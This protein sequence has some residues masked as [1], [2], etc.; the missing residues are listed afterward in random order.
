MDE[1]A[2]KTRLR[3]LLETPGYRPA[4]LQEIAVKLQIPAKGRQ[5]L[6]VLVHRLQQAGEVAVSENGRLLSARKAGEQKA[7]ILSVGVRGGQALLL[8]PAQDPGPFFVPKED[9]NGAM[10]TDIVS[11]RL[12]KQRGRPPQ[13]VVMSVSERGFQEFLGTFH[14]VGKNGYVLP[15]SKYRE[16]IRVD[17]RGTRLLRENDMVLAKM[18]QYPHKGQEAVAEV[19]SAYGPSDSARACCNAILDR[20]HIR[21]AFPEEVIAQAKALPKAVDA[22][23]RLDLRALP[24]FTIDGAES[25]DLDDAVSVQE[26]E[27]GVR[28]GVHIADVSHYVTPGS[29]LDN[30]AF[31][32]G[33]SVYYADQVVPMLPKELSNGIC[34]LNP[35]ED[36]LAFSAFMDIDAQGKV[37]GFQLAKSVIRSR[38]KGVYGEVNRIFAGTA[39]K[40]LLKKYAEVLPELEKMLPLAKLLHEA[41]TQRGAFDLDTVESELVID[42]NGVAVDVKKRERGEAERL[43]EEF[44]LCANEAVATYAFGKKLPFLYRVHEEPEQEKLSTLAQALSAAGISAKEIKP[45]LKPAAV[46]HALQKIANSPRAQALSAIVLRS[47]AKARYSPECKGHFGL[48]LEYYCHFTSPIRRYPDLAIHRIL[49]DAASAADVELSARY[50]AFVADASA[51]SSE[52]EVAAMQ[53]EWDCEDAYKAE[54]LSGHIGEQFA[55]TVTSVKSFGMYVTLDNTIEGLVRVET[56]PGGWY[57]YDEQSM[58]L[59]CARTGSAYTV[60]DAVR[61]LVARAD[62]PSGQIDF[63]LL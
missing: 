39:G 20:H 3:L 56:I 2:L 58:S 52:R 6:A 35:K 55:G 7:K 34:S 25:K 23:G 29:A 60:G 22:E 41:R 12:V 19:V 8:D 44:M 21:R 24:I 36:R 16:K 26:C 15:S 33:T 4:T 37:K 5:R 53:T 30:E 27:A 38:V 9:L 14:R 46:A 48:A 47:M 49:S 32:R 45:G 63:T 54:F 13:G 43:I 51:Q 61:V 42:E 28:L 57:D 40:T 18:R 59:R 31:G 11:L 62:V 17:G 1:Q 50:G 10:P